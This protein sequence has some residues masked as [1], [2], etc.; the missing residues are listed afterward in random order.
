MS[1]PR[2]PRSSAAGRITA[3]RPRDRDPSLVDVEVGG[4]V[5]GT[6]LRGAVDDLGLREGALL[7]AAR[8]TRLAEACDRAAARTAALRLLAR[9]D[10]SGAMLERHLVERG[11]FDASI[12]SATRRQLAADGWQDDRRYAM[13]RAERLARERQAAS[14]WILAALVDEGVAERL[15]R[16]AAGAAAPSAQDAARALACAKARLGAA[17][18][19]PARARSIARALAQRGYDEDLVRQTLDRLRLR[20]GPGSEE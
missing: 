16:E 19:T 15:A 11:G 9:S 12:A 8:R 1:P 2:A 10:R 7:S 20:I 3:L 14:A 18:R 6:I 17:A 13:A 5:V 4:E